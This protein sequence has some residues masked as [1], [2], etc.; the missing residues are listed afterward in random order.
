M[1]ILRY[2]QKEEQEL[3]PLFDGAFIENKPIAFPNREGTTAYSNLFYWAHLEAYE[4]SEFPLHPHEGFEIMTFVFKGSIEHYDT[5][6]KIWTA[7][8]EGGVQ[9][10]QAGSGVEH[11]E[12]ISKG[13]ELFQIWF[14]PDFSKTMKKN[15]TYK[16]YKKMSLRLKKMLIF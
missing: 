11:S 15:A 7:L 16:D 10:I 2:L 5:A 1:G 8:G 14:D 3:M 4:T 6:T 9:V 12:R 13:T